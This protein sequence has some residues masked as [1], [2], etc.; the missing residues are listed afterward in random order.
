MISVKRLILWTT[1]T[2]PFVAAVLATA[3]EAQPTSAFKPIDYFQESCVRCHG[4]YGSNYDIKHMAQ[5]SDEKLRAVIHAMAEGPG[6]APLDARQ[7]EIETAFHRS[8][9]DGKPFVT[10]TSL[11][12]EGRA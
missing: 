8:L 12:P 6:Q 3:Q 4:P 7:L 9:I 5:S 11:A 1:A 10:L 2:T